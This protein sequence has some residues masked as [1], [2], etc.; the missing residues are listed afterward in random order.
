MLRVGFSDRVTPKLQVG[1]G[2]GN[3]ETSGSGSGVVVACH[4]HRVWLV[5]LSVARCKC[6]HVCD[7][8]V[9]ERMNGPL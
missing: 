1:S 6:V 7:N 4:S 9:R 3:P 8:S 2:S 5:N